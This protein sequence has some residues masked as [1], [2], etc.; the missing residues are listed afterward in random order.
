MGVIAIG[1][2]AA[3]ISLVMGN[4]GYDAMFSFDASWTLIGLAA[5]T[6]SLPIRIG[7]NN[8]KQYCSYNTQL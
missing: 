8:D 6:A 3:F 2:V 7:G 1:L 4:L 5:A